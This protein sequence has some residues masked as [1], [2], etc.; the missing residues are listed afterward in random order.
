MTSRP[1]QRRR[2]HSDFSLADHP[3]IAVPRQPSSSYGA[4]RTPCSRD[5][6]RLGS[7]WT[8]K[9]GLPDFAVC[10]WCYDLYLVR[11][12]DDALASTVVEGYVRD[13]GNDIPTTLFECLER[14]DPADE[15][16]PFHCH[17]WSDRMR[18]LWKEASMQ[19]D[20]DFFRQRFDDRQTR[21]RQVRRRVDDL[22]EGIVNSPI[23][24]R[25]TVDMAREKE[26]LMKDWKTYWE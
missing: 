9:Y 4:R 2:S 3:S 26:W 25:G 24:D 10:E 15:S 8:F 12:H 6:P 7:R 20:I 22:T 16:T 1:P 5:Q 21:W 13:E 19:Q 14:V 18:K 17:M 11:L 23:G